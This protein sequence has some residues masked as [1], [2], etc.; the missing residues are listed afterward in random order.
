MITITKTPRREGLL[1]LSPVS[2]PGSFRFFDLGF[3][4]FKLRSWN[5]K[6]GL[7]RCTKRLTLERRG[8]RIT[9]QVRRPES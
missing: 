4:G 7:A 8:L 5:V 3:G 1:V 9:V 6:A 2:T